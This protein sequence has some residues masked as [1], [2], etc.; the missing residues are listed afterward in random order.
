MVNCPR[1]LFNRELVLNMKK[2]DIFI[3]GDCDENILRLCSL[4][5]WEDDLLKQ[6]KKTASN[7]SSGAIYHSAHLS[8]R[9]ISVSAIRYTRG[10]GGGSSSIIEE[11]HLLDS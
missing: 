9:Q 10:S 6:N 11:S 8:R 4:L 1:V 2:D 7:N 3:Q 5:E